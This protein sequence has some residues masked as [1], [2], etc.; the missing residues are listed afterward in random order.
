ML[1]IAASDLV[2]TFGFWASF[3]ARMLITAEALPSLSYSWKVYFCLHEFPA[4][5]LRRCRPVAAYCSMTAGLGQN[6]A[7]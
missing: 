4:N 7:Q 2:F 3:Q 6:P 5:A 1:L